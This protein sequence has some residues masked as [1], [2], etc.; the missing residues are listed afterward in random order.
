MPAGWPWGDHAA[1]IRRALAAEAGH[2]YVHERGCT[3]HFEGNGTISG[4]AVAPFKAACAVAGLPVIDT[5]MLDP[6]QALRL[7]IHSPMTCSRRPTRTAGPRRTWR[8]SSRPSTPGR[9][10][11]CRTGT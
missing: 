7:A 5:R 1:C 11:T 8:A 2:L 10:R 3:L 4:Y 9:R 6:R